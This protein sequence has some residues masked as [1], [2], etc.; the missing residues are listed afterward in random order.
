MRQRRRP[1]PR[2]RPLLEEL[3]PRVLFSA[4][5]AAGLLDP[6]HWDGQAEVRMIE[7]AAPAPTYSAVQADVA[8]LP[9][10]FERNEGQTDAQVDFV[11]RGSGYG[12]FLANGE[13]VLDIKGANG[14]HVVRLNL[15][16]A[17]T[18]PSAQGEDALASRSNY[19]VGDQSG[20]HTDI[21]NFAAVRYQDV[22]DGIDLRYYG[23]QRQLEYDFLIGAGA[24]PDAIRLAFEGVVRTEIAPDGDLLFTLNERGDQIRFDA[25]VSYQEGP[26][27]REAVASCYVI[28]ADGTVGFEVG[29]YDTSRDLVIDPVLVYGSFLGGTGVNKAQG[30]AIDAAGNAYLTGETAS[31]A[32]PTTAGAYDTAKSTGSDIFV[33]KLN[34]SGTGLVFSTFIGGSGDDVAWG[35]AL[36]ATGNA[37]VTGSTTSSNLPTLNAFQSALSGAQD[38]FFLKL[39][40]AG[41]ALAYSTYYGG[42]GNGDIAYAIAVDAAGRAYV[43]GDTNSGS[44]IA[45]AGAYDTALS[46]ATD[47]FLVKFDPTLSGAASRLFGTYLG[48]TADDHGLAVAVDAFGKAH[49]SGYTTS[50]N[51]ATT[52]SAYDAAY[53][54]GDDAFLTVFNAAGSAL[55][56][57]TYLG[58]GGNDS[59]SAIALDAAGKVYLSG[60]AGSGFITKNAYDS[61]YGGGT[62]DAF[63]AKLDPALSGGASL[64]YSTYLGG[65]GTET[66]P[67]IAVDSLGRAHVTG[68]TSGSFPTTAD[69]LQS[70]YAG[71]TNDAFYATLSSTGNSLAYSTYLGGSGDDVGYAIAPDGSDNIYLTGYTASSNFQQTTGGA[72]D[73]T[74]NGSYDAFV[75]KFSSGA[76]VVTTTNDVVDGATTSIAALLANKG[77]DGL[78][79]LREAIIATNNTAGADAISLAAGTYTLS[80]TGANEDASSTGDLD[81]TGDLTI[82]GV[83]ANTTFI[84]G[85]GLDRVFEVLGANATIS[86]VTVQNGSAGDGGGIHVSGS[87]TLRD[88]A[89]SGNSATAIGGGIL[90]SGAL[91]LDRVNMDGN[92]ADVGGGIN[93]GSGA[94]ATLTNVTMSGNTVT[95]V[96]GAISTR[97]AV[98]ITN[99]TIASNTA[100]GAGGVNKQASGSATLKNTI[101]SGNT[102]G[103][104]SGALTS[105][106]NNIDSANTAGLTGP[107]DR[108][109]TD[110]LLGPLQYNGGTTKTHSLLAG[111]LAI[112]AGTATGAPATDQR[113]TSRL[114]ATDIGAYEYTLIGYEPFAYPTGSFDGANGGSGWAAGWSNAGPDTTIAGTGLQNPGLAMPASGGTAQLTIPSSFGNVT[115]TRDLSTTVGAASTTTWLSFLVKPN[116][117]I[118]GDYIGVQFGSPSATRAFAGYNG[119][120]FV[121]EQLGGGGRVAV[122]GIT[123]VA[124]QTYLL[125]VKMDFTAGVNAMTLYVNPT[126]G[127]AGPDSAFTASKN[128]LDL[129]T[130]TQ[131]G[132]NGGRTLLSNNAAL[133][134]LRIAGSYLDVAPASTTTQVAPVI[135]SNGGGATAGVN[136]AENSTAVTTVTATDADLPAQTLSYSISGGVDAAKFTI[137]AGTGALSFVAAPN[138]EAPTDAGANNVYD[139]IVQVSDGALTDTQAIAV[140]VTDVSEPLQ[141]TAA[142]DTYINSGSANNFGTST[143]LVVDRSGG[144]LGNG[145]ALLQFD[146]SAIPVGATVTGATLQLQASANASPFMIDIYRLTE[147]WVEG[148]GGTSAANWNDRLPGTAWT[149]INGASV[150][151]TPAATWAT[152]PPA[153][154]GTHSWDLTNLVQA[155]QTGTSANYGILLGSTALGTTTVTYNSSEGVTPPRLVV[156][157]ALDV[158]PT[159]INLSAAESYTEDSALNL[160]DIVVSDI[161]SASV[162]ATLTLSNAAAGSLNIGTSGA[163]TSTYNAGTGVWSASGAIANVNTLLAGLTFT[164]SLNFNSSFTIATSVSD[165]VAAPITG[166]KPMTGTAVNDAPV[167]T[168]AR[169]T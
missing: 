21:A 140:T 133:D 151:P 44:G 154:A 144:G 115:Q 119:S 18:D 73:T 40:A 103:N 136:L 112:N 69:A 132:L 33:T 137:V 56:Y 82:T 159:A 169:T 88:A 67:G 107:G 1:P 83:G 12:V 62:W 53:N 38:A 111:S 50:S 54:G 97:G 114:G 166:S 87:L 3:E 11:A 145:R 160:T 57:S 35:I 96:G 155:W 24:D 117:T 10:A 17:A 81:I 127:L 165:G 157:Y 51:L 86:G 79:S 52:A 63:V 59:A 130:F 42:T 39:N 109:N 41:T 37:Y 9:L 167:L 89:V 121:L 108:I 65:A 141:I 75:V 99:S 60:S 116:S 78:I 122:G 55:T 34:S 46:G 95:S 85:A 74:Q 164:P 110:P 150:N 146:L 100:G 125:T 139:V 31:A 16:D 64:I 129:G 58:G 76:L 148:N 20:W 26:Y 32:F 77:A 128:N 90:V 102:G 68:I 113:G 6:N 13:A 8:S 29:A 147:A 105:L 70:T 120:Q 138:Y 101:L 5:A 19:L 158:A 143:S 153:G 80:R 14:G 66:A 71:G 27:G 4:D 28:H 124:G 25:P 152:L 163:V 156:S 2:Q 23:N 118:P 91:T 30:I 134:E 72:Y 106:G 7:P 49:V 142:Q 104:A 22:Y 161:D 149:N 84:D 15:V 135:T 168:R 123:P 94:S 126:P 93:V 61:T 92:R 131:I 43:A 47:A 162:T 48:G 98:T 45:S 36:D